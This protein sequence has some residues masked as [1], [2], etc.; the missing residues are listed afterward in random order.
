MTVALVWAQA[1]RGVI[2]AEGALPWRLP[3]DM[4]LF[5]ALTWGSTVVM[6]RLTWESLPDRMR[7]L[8][9]RDNVVLTRRADWAPAG[10]RVVHSRAEAL[11]S[12]E[13]NLWVIG[14]STVYA[15]FLPVADVLIRTD[16]DLEVAGD[17][18]APAVPA[19]WLEVFRSPESGWTMASNGLRYAWTELVPPTSAASGSVLRDALTRVEAPASP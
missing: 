8:P 9:G 7:P 12:Y 15:E 6:G 16:V 4:R 1:N 3:E 13:G 10:A 11:R 5:R 14:G 17:T 19:D 2:G 18:Y